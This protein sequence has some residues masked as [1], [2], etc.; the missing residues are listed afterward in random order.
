[1]KK[2][3]AGLLFVSFLSAGCGARSSQTEAAIAAQDPAGARRLPT[4]A[5]LDPAGTS[6][7]LGSMPL[8]M[9]L[10]PDKRQVVVLL[11]GWREQGIQIVDRASGQVSQT[12][13]LPAVFLGVAFSPDGKSLFVSGGNQ[14][15]VYRFN[16]NGG[17]ASLADSLVLAPKKKGNDG[18]KYPA[19]IGLSP[20][21]RMLYAAE[22][23]GDSLAVIDLATHSVVQRFATE[24]YPYGV[25]VGPDGSVY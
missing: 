21:G 11:N 22:N 14:D 20:D 2:R 18:I 24:R 1:M 25:V 16:W 8:A 19:G 7:D 6:T 5:T 13:T 10:S 17:Q 4:G 12:I 23:L 15:V 3:L 9:T